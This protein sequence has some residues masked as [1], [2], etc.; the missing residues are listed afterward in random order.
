MT[1]RMVILFYAPAELFSQPTG[2]S[3][4][5]RRLLPALLKVDHENVYLVWLGPV[6]KMPPLSDR[7]D[8]VPPRTLYF[9]TPAP[10]RL[11]YHPWV[12]SAFYYY[13]FL[14]LAE[15]LLGHPDLFFSPFY[16]FFP[17]RKGALALT[18]F[19]LTTL[20][21]PHCYPQ[22][23]RRISALTLLW[24]KKAHQV[25]TF[26][27][28]VRHQVHYRLSIPLEKITVTPLAPAPFFVPTPKERQ[29]QVRARYGLSFPYVLFVGTLQP[30]KNMPVLVRAFKK[31]SR[32]FPNHRLVLCGERGWQSEPVFRLIWDLGLREKVVHLTEVPDEDLPPLISGADL[33]AFPSLAEGFGLPPLEAM[34]CGTAVLCSDAPALPEVI[35]D[36]AILLPCDD[37]DAWAQALND[38]LSNP[39]DRQ[40]WAQKGL[41]RARAF[42]WE[43]TATET[44]KAFH[45]A[46]VRT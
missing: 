39:Q 33:F 12:R 29:D 45:R 17:F 23:L 31:I 38:L 10:T 32:S 37:E 44:L 2:A 30:R 46:V 8:T 7:A 24:S 4:Y 3:A 11:L 43:K 40:F 16:P 28:W 36:G 15:H 19:D 6:I 14:P 42:T 34:A 1:R 20:T 21:H 35:G 13:S 27:Q 18:I 41:E 26:S 22:T 9:R 5:V 25:L